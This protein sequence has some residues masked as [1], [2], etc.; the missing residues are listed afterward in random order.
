MSR[1]R[2]NRTEISL[3]NPVE[4]SADY[5]REINM[6]I[7]WQPGYPAVTHGAPED[8]YPGEAPEFEILAAI[9]DDGREVPQDI[10]DAITE[11]TILEH[12][13]VHSDNP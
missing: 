12:L 8:C 11:E 10:L 4:D 3:P 7:N 2:W 6:V 13:E 1:S 9:Y 5:D